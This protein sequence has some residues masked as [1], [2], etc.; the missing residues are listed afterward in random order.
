MNFTE[1]I[2]TNMSVVEKSVQSKWTNSKYE[3][4]KRA[5]TTTKGS[6]GEELV[7]DL[8]TLINIKASRIN[9]GKGSFDVLAAN[10]KW[11]VKLATEDTNGK[12]QFNGIMKDV[13]YDYVLCIGVAPNDLW[14]NIFTKSQC[15]QLSTAM[16]KGGSDT[17]K[18]TASKD[19]K[20]VWDVKRLTDELVFAVEVE[21]YV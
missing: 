12:F 15:Q 7:V 9:E 5:P 16:T 21:K 10:K 11:E 3:V 13:D 8:F 1:A 20:S 2:T 6:F 18:L 19:S 17:Y 14:F 4:I